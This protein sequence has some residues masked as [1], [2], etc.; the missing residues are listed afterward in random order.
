MSNLPIRNIGSV[1][2]V[3]DTD[4]FNLP[5]NAFTRGKNV[6]FSEG[7]VERAPIFREVKQLS[8]D[9]VFCMGLTAPGSY[10]T[11]LMVSDDLNIYEYANGTY[12]QVYTNPLP[13]SSIQPI[14]G[15]TLANVEYINRPD[16]APLYRGPTQ[17]TFSPLVNWPSGY[18]CGSLRS[19][20]D[21][22][23]AMNTT[24][25][26]ID[27]PNR[28]R[29][30]DL[31][32]AN[33]VPSTWDE[34]DTTNSAGFNDL[35]QMKTPIIDGATLGT[36]FLIY[37][38]DQVWQM[39]FV[40]GTFI[41]NFRK[42]FDD[43]GVIN[44][45]CIVEVEGRHYVFD[46]DDIYV[47]DG[48]TRQSIADRRVRDYVFKSIDRSKTDQC[49]VLHNTTLEEIYFCYHSGDDM[50]IRT[51]SDACNR[52]A[53]FN[54]RE[55]VWSFMDLPN[56]ISGTSGTVGT[57]LT[58]ASVPAGLTYANAGGT[59]HE[60]ESQYTMYPLMVSR[61]NN[62]NGISVPRLVGIDN[63]DKGFMA[64]PYEDEINSDILLERVG[65]DLDEAQIPLSGYKVITKVYPQASATNNNT[66]IAFEFG[67]ANYANELPN[68]G[69]QTT[70]DIQT[71]YKI[72]T[73]ASGRYLS[74]RINQVA[75][76][77][78]TFSGFDVDI[79]VTGRR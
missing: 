4:P 69:P 21:F 31:V 56:T 7:N 39:E 75:P 61:Q 73:R 52:A 35:V 74:Y 23:I 37:S 24:E 54:Y 58:F 38:S 48:V 10:S 14:T 5:F 36:N 25:G 26:G 16:N 44:K 45:N 65:I 8:F 43:A 32:V 59:Y 15:T 34:L 1:G 9:P 49:F 51:D 30:S 19:Y 50:A 78:F 47:N 79:T 20:G 70:F 18:T 28:V 13:S 6:R 12:T 68:Y 46:S 64:F 60:Q 62:A 72:D 77:D 76:A 11:I 29:F 63:I 27:F 17:T 41:F 55:N 22:L 66:Q 57:V 40:G 3:T 2:V 67:A 71:G 53:V 33:Q 42:V